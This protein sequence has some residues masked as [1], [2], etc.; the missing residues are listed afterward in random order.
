MGF[1]FSANGVAQVSTRAAGTSAAGDTQRIYSEQSF[2]DNI[3]INGDIEQ[4]YY[5][6]EFSGGQQSCAGPW[7]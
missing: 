5:S 7:H 1:D 2:S 6:A 4:F 3:T